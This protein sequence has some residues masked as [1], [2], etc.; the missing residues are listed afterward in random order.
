MPYQLPLN[1]VFCGE[2][3]LAGIDT[4]TVDG[5][6]DGNLVGLPTCEPY[7]CP[8]S[9]TISDVDIIGSNKEATTI[10]ITAADPESLIQGA[11]ADSTLLGPRFK[12]EHIFYNRKFGTKKETIGSSG[13]TR[14]QIRGLYAFQRLSERRVTFC[15][16]DPVVGERKNL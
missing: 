15:D 1:A 8:S 9:P 12:R 2:T 10:D 11:T 13:G 5:L 16:F 4:G 14:P 7:C 3:F 6:L